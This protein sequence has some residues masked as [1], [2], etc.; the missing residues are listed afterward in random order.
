MWYKIILLVLWIHIVGLYCDAVSNPNHGYRKSE[1][2][3]N[4]VKCELL[5]LILIYV[6]MVR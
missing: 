6:M 3:L 4:R 2:M 1:F 5:V